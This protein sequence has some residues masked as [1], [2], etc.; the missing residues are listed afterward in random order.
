MFVAENLHYLTDL[1]CPASMRIAGGLLGLDR[2]LSTGTEAVQLA[3]SPL[4]ATLTMVIAALEWGLE[5]T[6]QPG[7][8]E[9]ARRYFGFLA[10]CG[11]RPTPVER[12]L[13]AG[14]DPRD[15]SAEQA[16]VRQLRNAEYDLGQNHGY[17][18]M[19]HAEYLA[20]LGPVAAELAKLGEI[21]NRPGCAVRALLPHPPAD[22]WSAPCAV[23][24]AWA[25]PRASAAIARLVRS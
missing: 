8:N 9:F 6:R 11:Y 19:T 10:E 22:R 7:D 12:I 3:G 2:E 16:R 24:S 1:M 4:G 14:P 13:A 18:L 15:L 17:T 21:P 5:R 25:E 23:R 20:A